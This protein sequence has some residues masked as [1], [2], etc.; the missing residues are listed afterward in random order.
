MPE[1]F[2]KNCQSSAETIK[3][4]LIERLSSKRWPENVPRQR[5]G[6]WLRRFQRYAHA[7]Y[8]EKDHISI[9]LTPLELQTC[10]RI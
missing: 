5:G 2:W 10:F 1:G 4:S 8:P 3:N 6:F 9:L 7:S